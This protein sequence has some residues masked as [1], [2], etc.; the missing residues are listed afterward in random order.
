MKTSAITFIAI[1]FLT[2]D[3]ARSSAETINLSTIR[4]AEFLTTSKEGIGYAAASLD[5]FH[6]TDEDDPLIV[7]S[8]T[9]RAD[10][11]R[12]A[13]FCRRVLGRVGKTTSKSKDSS[14][15]FRAYP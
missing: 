10:A 12:L 8:D 2:G 5:A 4:C 11:K 1:G 9:L 3:L 7:D 13:D 14:P 6:H 15:G